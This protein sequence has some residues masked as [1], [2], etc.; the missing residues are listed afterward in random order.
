VA[1]SLSGYL[2][3]LSFAKLAGYSRPIAWGLR[4]LRIVFY[5]FD[6]F[7]K[8]RCLQAAASLAYT[9][10]LSLVPLVAISLAVLSRFKFSQETIQNFLMEHFLPEASFQT[11]VM[12]NIQKFASQTAALSIIGGLFL[13]VTAVALLNTVEGSFNAIWRVTDKRSLLSKFTA[14]WSII[15]FSP[16]LL[17]ASLVLTSRFYTVRY[18]GELLRQELIQ[19]AIHFILPVFLI[20]IIIFLAYRVLPHTKV[21]ASPALIGAIIATALFSY[22]R[23][24][25]GIYVSE[26]AHFDKIYGILG[27]LPAFLIWVYISWVIVLFGAE[28]AYTVQYHRLDVE[29]K[30]RALADTLYNPYY[31]VRVVLA[32]SHHFHEGKGPLSKVELGDALEV[33]YELLDEILFKL[34]ERNI[35]ASVDDARERFLPAKNPD[36]I[37]VKAV[38]DAMQGEQLV[39]PSWPE[40]RQKDVIEDV[41]ESAKGASDDILGRITI[42]E[43][44]DRLGH[45]KENPPASKEGKQAEGRS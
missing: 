21:K 31:G 5:I 30:R 19:S 44:S 17:G 13:A 23:W 27:T 8:D 29:E 11:V 32:L 12:E 35:V 10:L 34:K 14:F 37:T 33:T 7:A 40:D 26:Y 25:F 18:V 3:D 39:A 6:E 15:T 16:I 24:V 38:V 20:F 45:T 36:M 4:F 28:V 41:F 9:T 42:K 1:G 43:V 2:A 22:A